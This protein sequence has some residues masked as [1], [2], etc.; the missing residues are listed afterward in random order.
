MSINKQMELYHKIE[1][2]L[3]EAAKTKH[4]MTIA[5]IFEA[6]I[7]NAVAKTEVQ[8]RDK[9]RNLHE[10]GLLTRITVPASEAD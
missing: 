10:H 9:V 6:P 4:A 2:V 8:V 7:V 3:R 5:D 1:Q